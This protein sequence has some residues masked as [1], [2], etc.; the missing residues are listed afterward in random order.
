MTGFRPPRFLAV[1]FS[2]LPFVHEAGQPPRSSPGLMLRN[3]WLEDTTR[4]DSRSRV[5]ET[6]CTVSGTVHRVTLDFAGFESHGL[7]LL[8]CAF[9]VTLMRFFV[10]PATDATKDHSKRAATTVG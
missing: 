6:T 1:A 7:V 3:G 4:D 9:Q 2:K 10:E 5:L 8:A